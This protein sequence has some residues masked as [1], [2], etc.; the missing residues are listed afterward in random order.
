M[1]IGD[2]P[3]FASEIRQTSIEALQIGDSPGFAFGYRN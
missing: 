1:Q 2:S 3:G